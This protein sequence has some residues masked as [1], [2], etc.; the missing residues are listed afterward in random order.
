MRPSLY[1]SVFIGINGKKVPQVLPPI[2]SQ[3]LK[4]RCIPFANDPGA[5]TD[6]RLCRVFHGPHA[7]TPP[8]CLRS[9]A[10]HVSGLDVLPFSL[11][12]RFRLFREHIAGRPYWIKLTSSAS[13]HPKTET[14]RQATFGRLSCWLWRIFLMASN[15]MQSGQNQQTYHIH[16]NK[17]N[18]LRS[19]HAY[20]NEQH[21]CCPTACP[22]GLSG[23]PL[24]L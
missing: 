4:A 23:L 3:A 14:I 7:G 17:I 11:C 16:I 15:R 5:H 13:I 20:R 9:P 12:S 6:I 21:F 24:H 8:Y 19:F 10:A 18:K 2:F 22:C 1:T